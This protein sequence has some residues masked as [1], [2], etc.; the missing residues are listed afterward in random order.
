M[1]RPILS[2]DPRSSLQ[3][4]GNP[5]LAAAFWLARTFQPSLGEAM[6]GAIL[7]AVSFVALL[8]RRFGLA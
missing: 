3:I 1:I 5:A 4:G 8:M 2:M 7:F 6:A